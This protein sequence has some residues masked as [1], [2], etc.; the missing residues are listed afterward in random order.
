MRESLSSF[1]RCLG[2]A[3]MAMSVT[4]LAHRAQ[5]A[6]VQDQGGD[7]ISVRTP[8][9][10]F[11]LSGQVKSKE[12]GLPVYPGATFIGDRDKNGGNLAFSLTR[13]EKPDVKFVVAKFETTDDIDQV[14][15]FYRKKLGHKVTKV[16]VDVGHGSV[17]FEM[18]ADKQHARFVAL[19][20]S[21]GRT[22]IDLVRLDGFDVSDTS[23]N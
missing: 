8:K 18:R 16:S 14:R 21:E 20:Q 10:G 13:P 7:E 2:M 1:L 22:E 17:S 23:V 3:A 11:D 6:P 12:I 5:A 4:T 15:D 19:K 9:G